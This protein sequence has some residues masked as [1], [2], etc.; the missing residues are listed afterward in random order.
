M[1][2]DH[3]EAAHEVQAAVAQIEEASH[4]TT[5][6]ED[7]NVE[8]VPGPLAASTP[9]MPP[10]SFIP[11]R[12]RKQLPAGP[13]SE[14]SAGL[15]EDEAWCGLFLFCFQLLVW[16]VVALIAIRWMSR[17]TSRSPSFQSLRQRPKPRA[18]ERVGRLGGEKEKAEAEARLKQRN[19]RLRPVANPQPPQRQRPK[20]RR[21]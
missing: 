9:E 10:P 6:P 19:E 3:E 7:P 12:A 15:L 8:K 14:T 1:P 20:G 5:T 11:K 18:R 2:Y 4:V 21:R 16:Q 13:L 17:G